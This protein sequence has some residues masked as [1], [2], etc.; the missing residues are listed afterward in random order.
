MTI[1]KYLDLIDPTFKFGEG[2]EYLRQNYYESLKGQ[3]TLLD[4]VNVLKEDIMEDL[5]DNFEGE[6]EMSVL[7]DIIPTSDDECMDFFGKYLGDS[8]CAHPELCGAIAGIMFRCGER[9]KVLEFLG[10]NEEGEPSYWDS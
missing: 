5:A 3:Q 6:N 7:L 2:G 1:S 8:K 10:V 9:E 4:I